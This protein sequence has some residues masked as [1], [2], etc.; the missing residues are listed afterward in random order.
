MEGISI[1]IPIYNRAH[2]ISRCLDS[3]Y[4]QTHRPLRVIV[5]DNNSTDSSVAAVE[6]WRDDHVKDGDGFELEILHESKPG[7]ASARNRGLDAVATEWVY[8][9]DSDDEMAPDLVSKGLSN[10]QDADLVTWKRVTVGLDGRHRVSGYS[11]GDLLQRHVY[12]SVLSTQN[13]MIRTTLLRQIG[14]WNPEAL[15]W[16]DWELGIRI[17]TQKM[18]VKH[19]DYVAATLY[20]QEESITGTGYLHARERYERTIALVE[21]YADTLAPEDKALLLDRLTYI[22]TRL[23]AHYRREGRSD[24]AKKDLQEAL[25]KS[26]LSLAKKIWLRL[27]YQYTAIGGRGAWRLWK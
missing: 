20:S 21:Q 7:A 10:A 12:N 26:S 5:V 24:L 11:R 1:V 15:V 19:L 9:F 14:G 16:D 17:A 8:F 18:R 3:A 22:R 13:Y 2:L 23:A 6:A 4:A 25:H 27:L